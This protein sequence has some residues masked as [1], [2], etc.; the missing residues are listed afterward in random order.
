MAK[1]KKLG[2]HSVWQGEYELRTQQRIKRKII[3]ISPAKR[4]ELASLDYSGGRGQCHFCKTS[5]CMAYLKPC[6]VALFLVELVCND[7]RVA[8]NLP[9]I[10]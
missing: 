1:Q 5:F 8:R 6:K 10:K 7:C 3:I 2:H 4:R 9:V